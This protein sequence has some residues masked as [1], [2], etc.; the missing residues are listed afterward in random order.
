MQGILPVLG[1]LILWFLGGWSIWLDYDVAPRTTTRCWTVP[2]IHWQIGGAFVIAV[3]T[4]LIGVPAYFYC[5]S[6]PC[7][8][9][10]AD[11]DPVNGDLVPDP[12]A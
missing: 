10:E 1:G 7:L 8:L 5:R 4:G 12:D 6:Q 11:A 3:V 9:Q 2:V